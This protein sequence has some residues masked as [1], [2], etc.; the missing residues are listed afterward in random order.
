MLYNVFKYVIITIKHSQQ[1]T[2]VSSIEQ[3]MLNKPGING[4]RNN[5]PRSLHSTRLQ[6]RLVKRR[7]PPIQLT[8]AVSTHGQLRPQRHSLHMCTMQPIGA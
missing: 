8:T 3:L 1:P 5:K 6:L 7:S 2:T 4:T